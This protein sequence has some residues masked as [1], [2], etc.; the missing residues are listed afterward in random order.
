MTTLEEIKHA[1]KQFNTDDRH[2]IA[3]W[4]DKLIDGRYVSFGVEE[5]Q[6]AYAALNPA[7]MTLDE[8]L[9]FAEHSPLRYE[10]VNGVIHA[11]TGPSIAHCRIAG[12]LLV[13]VRSHLRGGPCE[14][15]ATGANLHIRS[16]TDEILYIPDLIVACNRHEWDKKWI[17]NPKL[18][19]EILSPSTRAIDQRE[20]TMTYRRVKSIEEFVLIEQSE[21]T[22]TVHRRAEKW[23]PQVYSGPEANVEFQSIALSLPLAQIYAGTL[24]AA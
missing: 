22:V 17:C 11:M 18:V 5:P 10:Y 9:E 16:E 2:A 1:L 21:P 6:P 15:F 23:R 3:S 14:A 13:A 20:K 12:E 8:F 7:F 24:P 19:A 4:L